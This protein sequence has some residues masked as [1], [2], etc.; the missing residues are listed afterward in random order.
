MRF[1]FYSGLKHH[2]LKMRV[3]ADALIEKGH[4]VDFLYSSNFL[5][6]DDS[7][8][9]VKR[10]PEYNWIHVS[11]LATLAEKHQQKEIA[12][13]VLMANPPVSWSM[14]SAYISGINEA[15][16]LIYNT[17][18]VVDDYDALFILHANN[19]FARAVASVF[20]YKQKPV[21]AFQ[22]GVLRERDQ[23]TMRKQSS[24]LT[25]CTHLFVWDEESRQAY[26]DAG[27]PDENLTVAGLLHLSHDVVPVENKITFF[28][29]FMEE[30]DGDFDSDV[31]MLR[32]FASENNLDL[33][34]RMHPMNGGDG[35]GAIEALKSSKMVFTQNSTISVEAYHLG[36]PCVEYAPSGMGDS[37]VSSYS[38]LRLPKP[39]KRSKRSK[40]FLPKL[41]AIVEKT[42]VKE[43]D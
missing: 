14:A 2:F 28:V 32:R 34:V 8:A 29:P 12:E 31:A 16:E 36:V 23:Q 18:K 19:F 22:E 21:F 33:D 27:I 10:Y 41:V 17:R 37:D 6:I 39:R 7:W 43:T 9:Y 26:L 5:N 11:E 13:S 15:S 38:D 25:Y 1:L 4:T 42:C 30:Y 40:S 3:V 24:A 35:F 20:V